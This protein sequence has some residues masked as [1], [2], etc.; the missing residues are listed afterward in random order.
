MPMPAPT[1]PTNIRTP[2]PPKARY[3]AAYVTSANHDCA[4]HLAPGAVYENTSWCG[5]P[6]SRMYSP[7][8]KCQKN[9]LSESFTNPVAQPNTPKNAVNTQPRP[10]PRTRAGDAGASVVVAGAP[11]ET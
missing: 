3:N 6:W 2:K 7:V 4:T 5:M 10:L 11:V 9:E 8:F 1:A